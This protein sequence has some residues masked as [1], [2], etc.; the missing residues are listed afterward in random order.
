MTTAMQGLKKF[1]TVEIEIGTDLRDPSLPAILIDIPKTI[2]D[3]WL[4]EFET[5]VIEVLAKAMA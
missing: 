2:N 5:A 1:E 4:E 3:G